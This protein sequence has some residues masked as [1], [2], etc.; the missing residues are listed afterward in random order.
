[1][2][3]TLTLLASQATPLEIA[4]PA[5]EGDR[6]GK[7]LLALH[8]MDQDGISELAV[9]A[10]T[11][12]G[13][14]RHSGSVLIL[15]GANR[16]ILQTWRGEDKRSGFGDTLRAAGDSNGDGIQDVLVGYERGGRTEILSGVDGSMLI[17]FDRAD[18]E[19]SPFGDLDQ[20]GAD[21]FLLAG[22]QL[23]VRSGRDGSFLGGHGW[24]DE[25]CAFHSIGDVDGDGLT[26]GVLLSEEPMLLLTGT[27]GEGQRWSS[28]AYKSRKS[29]SELYAD[30]L[31]KSKA[32]FIR[33]APCS[34]LDGDGSQEFTAQLRIAEKF[35]LWAFS[36]TPPQG[37][38]ASRWRH[39]QRCM[40]LLES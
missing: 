33:C 37:L 38:E 17:S 10:P 36:V 23:E 13:E 16:E 40:V 31:K 30:L 19:V 9:G 27:L 25:G 3:F 24:T 12:R 22:E 8:D 15:S 21:D 20:D 6:F 29:L 39:E 26:D 28:F 18:E 7:A 34:D 1:M 35:E 11:A 32:Q 4:A 5:P 14:L 2:L